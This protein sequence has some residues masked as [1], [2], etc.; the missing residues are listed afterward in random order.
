MTANNGLPIHLSPSTDQAARIEKAEEEIV[1]SPAS[2]PETI[3][4]VE[5]DETLREVIVEVLRKEQPELW[6]D[7]ASDGVEALGKIA[8]RVP[9]LL[10]TNIVMPKMDGFALLKALHKR[11]INLPTL[12]TSGY[13]KQEAFEKRLTEE[14]ITPK[15]MILFLQKPFRFEQL[16][17]LL[18]KLRQDRHNNSKS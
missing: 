10:I 6:I 9:S 17:E 5:D 11:G 16:G 7:T 13:W 14:A 1:V 4:I 3:L 8:I 18:E 15:R 2:L 12:V